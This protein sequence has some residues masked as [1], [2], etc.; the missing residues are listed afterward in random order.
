MRLRNVKDAKELVSNNSLVIDELLENTFLNKNPIHL[1]IGT[2]KGDFLIGMAKKYPNINFVGIE[3]YESVLI[4]ALEKIEDLPNNLRF[5]AKD[6]KNIEEFIKIKIDALYLNFSDPWPKTRHEKRRL[7]SKEFLISYE[8]LF[9]KEINIYQKT[10]NKSLFAFSLKSLSQNG[11]VFKEVS[12]DLH[13][14]D[15]PNVTTEY[16][17]KFSSLGETINYLHAFKKI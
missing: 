9:N 8:K 17:R 7:T 13:Q 5:M 10:D 15:I 1:E 12:L 6:A 2:G 14:T 11:Y 4:R 3:K 16:E